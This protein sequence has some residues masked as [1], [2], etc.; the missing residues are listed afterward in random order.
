MVVETGPRPTQVAPLTLR[1]RMTLTLLVEARERVRTGWVQGEGAVDSDGD[2]VLCTDPR[3]AAWCLSD[4]LGA[5]WRS[6]RT[7]P[8]KERVRLDAALVGADSALKAVLPPIIDS[9]VEWN[10]Y[11]AGDAAE[12]VAALDRAIA[13]VETEVI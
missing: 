8:A 10:D 7:E 3:A 1:K 12:V 4:A 11:H 5:A 13:H 2:R 6:R 9:L